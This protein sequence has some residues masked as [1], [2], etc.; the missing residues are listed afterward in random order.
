MLLGP[1]GFLIIAVMTLVILALVS[2]AR[3]VPAGQGHRRG[4]GDTT[5]TTDN[6]FG[7]SDPDSSSAHHHHSD[8]VASG[9]DR[10]DSTTYDGDS[11]GPDSGSDSD[12]SS[13]DSADAG[14]S[15][16]TSD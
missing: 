7:S 3:S 5:S 11:T 13:G 14:D 10:C 9:A 1:T 15:A 12:A 8:P 16:S 2:K 6:S 4:A